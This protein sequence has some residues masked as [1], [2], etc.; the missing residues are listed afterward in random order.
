[1]IFYFTLQPSFSGHIF[2]VKRFLLSVNSALL[3]CLE[4]S[5]NC[6]TKQGIISVFKNIFTGYTNL[7]SDQMAYYWLLSPIMV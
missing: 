1:M 5:R 3:F 2:R 6:F 7:T 4:A